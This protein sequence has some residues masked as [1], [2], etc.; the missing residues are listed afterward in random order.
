MDIALSIDKV[1]SMNGYHLIYIN[2]NEDTDKERNNIE[3]LLMQNVDGLIIAPVGMDCSYMAT[4]IADRC[5][6]VF[7]DRKPTGFDRDIIMSTNYEGAFEGTEQLIKQGHTQIG[8]VGSRYDETMHERAD[9]YR[10]AL[11]KHGIKVDEDLIKSGS[12]RPRPMDDQR[13]GDSYQ[14]TKEL[15]EDKNVTALFCANILAAL[16]VS[17]FLIENANTTGRDF[18][19]ASFDDAFWYS[20]S[21]PPIIGVQQNKEDIGEKVAM[22]LLKRIKKSNDPIQE[23]RIPTTLILR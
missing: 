22:T 5:P 23:Y 2:S 8:F 20:M 6:C 11:R 12:G 3:S 16:G 17:N 18:G 1:M 21:I 15:I 13:I 19:V 14:L 4:V 7:F 10:G 9:G